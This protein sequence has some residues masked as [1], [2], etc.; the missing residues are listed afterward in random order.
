[1]ALSTK[2]NGEMEKP[3]GKVVSSTL[4]E[5]FTKESGK[6]IKHMVSAFTDIL[7]VQSIEV[8]GSKINNTERELK[9]GQTNLN[10]KVTLLM[11]QSTAQGSSLGLTARAT[12]ANSSS[13][14]SVAMVNIDGETRDAIKE[15]GKIIRCMAVGNSHGR[16]AAN[17]LVTITK[18]KKKEKGR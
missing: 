4:M 15:P 7:M 9:P 2:V 18:T 12:K 16:M 10:M 11:E 17:T 13:T 3:M 14:I 8:T 6:T 1:M 5:I